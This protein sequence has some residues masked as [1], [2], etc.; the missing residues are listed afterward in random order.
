MSERLGEATPDDY[1]SAF[2]APPYTIVGRRVEIVTTVL[3]EDGTIAEF[4]KQQDEE[5]EE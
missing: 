3:M 5:S 4:V 1:E 2:A